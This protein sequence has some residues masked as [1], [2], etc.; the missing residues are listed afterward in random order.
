[1]S[2]LEDMNEARPLDLVKELPNLNDVMA[3][4]KHRSTFFEMV[5]IDSLELGDLD[6]FVGEWHENFDAHD[7]DRRSLHDAIGMTFKQ[8][9]AWVKDASQ[10]DAI[11][12][13][14]RDA[15]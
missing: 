11:Y 3:V 1:M 14:Y 10:L 9:Q 15:L 8:Y 4:N 7:G 5:D 12:A 6:W 13:A 2:L